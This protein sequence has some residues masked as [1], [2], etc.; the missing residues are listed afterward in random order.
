MVA[1]TQ[2]NS[3]TT[4][5]C[6]SVHGLLQCILRQYSWASTMH[7]WELYGTLPHFL[8]PFL[9]LSIVQQHSLLVNYWTVSLLL[10]II[11]VPN[12]GCTA[13][14]LCSCKAH[15]FVDVLW[16]MTWWSYFKLWLRILQR[17]LPDGKVSSM[18]H[19]GTFYRH[20]WSVSNI[21]GFNIGSHQCVEQRQR[22]VSFGSS[23][24]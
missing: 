2:G 7:L 3:Q 10:S 14:K 5:I 24:P 21:P 22:A 9:L 18:N 8:S 17:I 23:L 16:Y 1:S 4:C 11:G 6:R 13:A 20:L 19:M 12:C 15:V